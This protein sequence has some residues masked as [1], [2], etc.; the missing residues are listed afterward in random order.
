MSH[1][2]GLHWTRLRVSPHVSGVCASQWFTAV[3]VSHCSVPA[4]FTQQ[5]KDSTSVVLCSYQQRLNMCR[6]IQKPRPACRAQYKEATPSQMFDLDQDHWCFSSSDYYTHT[7]L[8]HTIQSPGSMWSVRIQA[9]VEV[10]DLTEDVLY[11]RTLCAAFLSQSGSKTVRV[12][13]LN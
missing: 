10:T 9:H 12:Q 8:R 5:H 1:F 3:K 2:T 13:K 6:N 4:V 11:I 7:L